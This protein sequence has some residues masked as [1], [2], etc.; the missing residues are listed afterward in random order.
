[1]NLF[2]GATSLFFL[3]GSATYLYQSSFQIYLSKKPKAVKPNLGLSILPAHTIL[4]FELLILATFHIFSKIFLIVLIFLNILCAQVMKFRTQKVSQNVAKRSQ[5]YNSKNILSY[6]W[7]PLAFFSVCFIQGTLLLWPDSSPDVAVFHEPLVLSI[8][9]HHGFIW[10]QILNQYYGSIP[11]STH[12]IAAGIVAISHS[13][14]AL[15]LL[16][17]EVFWSFILLAISLASSPI[18]MR[19]LMAIPLLIANGYVFRASTDGLQDIQRSCF[20]VSVIILL[21][22]TL[23]KRSWEYFVP[24][25][26]MFA[27][28]ISSKMSELLLIP[29]ILIFLT[30]WYQKGNANQ[31]MFSSFKRIALM[32]L[33]QRLLIVIC[34]TTGSYFYIRNI[35]LTG[36][37]VYPF[38]F[39]HP[40]LSDSY[41]NTYKIDLSTPFNPG[42]R[43]YQRNFF[44]IQSWFDFTSAFRK[45][46]LNSPLLIAIFLCIL[47]TFFVNRN[48]R[49]L[50]VLNVIMYFFWYFLM[51]NDVRWALPSF[52]LSC[53]ISFYSMDSVFTM[54]LRRGRYAFNFKGAVALFVISSVLIYY[55]SPISGEISRKAKRFRIFESA[56]SH[57]KTRDFFYSN[58]PNLALFDY[59]NFKHLSNVYQNEI[60][61]ANEFFQL[62]ENSNQK[63]FVEKKDIP[64]S[65]NFFVASKNPKDYL[66][67]FNN[68]KNSKL[69]ETE[70][71]FFLNSPYL[72]HFWK[73]K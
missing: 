14:Y 41:M 37:P 7:G 44:E 53:S 46:F 2:L 3:V 63:P 52:V 58:I 60:L 42:D 4:L 20:T 35:F 43:N 5:S 16:N 49:K 54:A 59:V 31:R 22:Y 21:H 25:T 67:R 1:M 33:K 48:L 47:I 69:F 23:V 71:T 32:I 73:K 6:I 68:R 26:M 27:L 28:S 15:H 13:N 24:M 30:L 40:G 50:I 62:Y 45:Y 11:L 61:N 36:N 65:E 8:V 19:I 57:G 12:T 72:V 39:G 66:L 38:I 10:P 34:I 55:V 29:W 18:R 56:L 17:L 51:F 64:I 70:I 9:N